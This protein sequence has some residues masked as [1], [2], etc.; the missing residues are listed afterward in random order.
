[1]EGMLPITRERVP[2]SMQVV[3]FLVVL[4]LSNRIARRGAPAALTASATLNVRRA[5]WLV[6]AIGQQGN[7]ARKV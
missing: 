4:T 1:M 7:E 6:R 2:F 3:D 5:E